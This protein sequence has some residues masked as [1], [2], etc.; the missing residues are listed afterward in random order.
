[1]YDT[2]TVRSIYRLLLPLAPAHAFDRTIYQR[3]ARSLILQE[4]ARTRKAIPKG[5]TLWEPTNNQ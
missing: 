3:A 1:M 4:F 5:K 2:R